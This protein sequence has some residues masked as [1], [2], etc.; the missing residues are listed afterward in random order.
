MLLTLGT[1]LL[2]ARFTSSWWCPSLV[3]INFES[4]LP[5]IWS[6]ALVSWKITK[7]KPESCFTWCPNYPKLGAHGPEIADPLIHHVH[8]AH[9]AHHAPQL[10]P[11]P[12]WL[13]V[14]W[15]TFDLVTSLKRLSSKSLWRLL[16]A[17]TATNRASS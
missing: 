15:V 4:A 3:L 8:H 14:V 12:R 7:P 9:H 17:V 2:M 5:R 10:A 16:G 13:W 11:A 1:G 6:T